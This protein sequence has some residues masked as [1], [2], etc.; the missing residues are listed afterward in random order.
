[1]AASR[2][3]DRK[4]ELG[5]WVRG[6]A[7]DWA[8][9]SGQPLDGVTRI[10]GAVRKVGGLLKVGVV[11]RSGRG[12]DCGRMGPAPCVPFV[13]GVPPNVGGTEA[14]RSLRVGLRVGSY[15]AVEYVGDITPPEDKTLAGSTVEMGR[16]EGW[17]RAVPRG[18]KPL[19]AV[20]A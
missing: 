18:P 8:G 1:M 6:G 15:F 11:G 19:T 9:A 5:D 16:A 3:G 12:W 14:G 10:G 17:R 7:A 2:P 4:L 20:P 13:A